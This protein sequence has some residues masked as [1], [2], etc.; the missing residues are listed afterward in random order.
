MFVKEDSKHI[1]GDLY[2]PYIN[3][4]SVIIA[5]NHRIYDLGQNSMKE[6]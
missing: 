5:F 3:Q 6:T 1:L 4:S 2:Y